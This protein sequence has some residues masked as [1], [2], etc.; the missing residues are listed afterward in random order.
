MCISAVVRS[1]NKT[2][3]SSMEIKIKKGCDLPVAGGVGEAALTAPHAVAGKVVAIVPDD[4]EGCVWKVDV[5]PGDSVATGDPL[6]HSKENENVKIVSPVAGQVGEVVRGERRHVLRVTVIA[7][8]SGRQRTFDTAGGDASGLLARSGLLAMMRQ[9]PYSTVPMPDAAP[10]DIFVT[11]FDSAPL[12]APLRWTQ[13]DKA[14]FDAAVA[15][16]AP[17]TKGKIYVSR[18]NSDNIPDIA[19]AVMVDVCGPHPAGL[20]GTVIDAVRPVNKGEV[21]WTLNADTL[22]KIG[23]LATGGTVDWRN[24]V[25]VTGSCLEKPYVALATPGTEIQALT[26]PAGL[27]PEAAAS[28]VRYIS[29]NILSGINAGKDGFLHYPYTQVTVIPE[30]DDTDEF[31]GW[32]SLSPRLLSLSPS[33]PGHWLKRL[34]KPDARVRGGRRGMIMSG[35]YENLIPLDILPEYLIKAIN[36]QNIDE[37]E[38]LGIY[39]VAPEDFALAEFADTSKLPLQ[40]IVRDGLDLMRREG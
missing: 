12:A 28:H 34:F 26:A 33:Y 39:E 19:G 17:L 7:D 23:Q 22:F 36:S 13:A 5:H 11:A 25:A 30:G 16:L 31:M 15:F 32:A 14:V 1:D 21:V 10:R 37:M 40:Q 20:A 29:G 27:T 35:I 18:R 3:N 38:R 8:G 6:M 24:R 2:H 4:F 9:R